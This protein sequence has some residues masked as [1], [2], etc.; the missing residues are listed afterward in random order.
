MST[1]PLSGIPGWAWCGLL[2]LAACFA[3][4][5]IVALDGP[6]GVPIHQVPPSPCMSTSAVHS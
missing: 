5:C 2:V 1:N 3:I 4:T 6:S